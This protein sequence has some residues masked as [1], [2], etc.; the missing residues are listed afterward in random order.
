[1]LRIGHVKAFSSAA[2]RRRKEARTPKRPGTAA[3]THAPPATRGLPTRNAGDVLAP[4]PAQAEAAIWSAKETGARLVPRH[5]CIATAPLR[6]RR[7]RTGTARPPFDHR[8][9]SPRCG[10]AY[11]RPPAL[12]ARMPA[13]GMRSCSCAGLSIALTGGG[14]TL[15]MR[16]DEPPACH[17]ASGSNIAAAGE[18]ALIPSHW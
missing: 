8:P 9:R 13:D 5:Q 7:S 2:V 12:A 15:P 1:M 3:G 10:P 14:R 17:P 4:T 11:P 18:E 16:R 6:G